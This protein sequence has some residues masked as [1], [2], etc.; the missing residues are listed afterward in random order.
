VAAVYC[1]VREKEGRARE[2]N[3]CYRGDS[4]RVLLAGCCGTARR[5]PRKKAA[6]GAL[7]ALERR[8]LRDTSNGVSGLFGALR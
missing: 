2:E 8:K 3:G 5:V 1:S 7:G 4:Q 6:I